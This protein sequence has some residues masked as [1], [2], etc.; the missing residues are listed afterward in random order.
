MDCE[1]QV[2]PP[3]LELYTLPPEPSTAKMILPLLSVHTL[4]HVSEGD[5]DEE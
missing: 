5:D 4:V 3:S 2:E 1:D